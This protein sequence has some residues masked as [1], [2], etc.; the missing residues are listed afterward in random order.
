MDLFASKL[1]DPMDGHY[2]DYPGQKSVIVRIEFVKCNDVKPFGKGLL[3]HRSNY[4]Y[5]NDPG[6]WRTNVPNYREIFYENIYDNID[7]RFYFNENRLKY[8]F[9]VLPGGEPED[10]VISV[11]G[12]ENLYID[13]N[14]DLI[15]KSSFFDIKDSG[16]FVFQEN[17]D[18]EDVIDAEFALL[19]SN[20]Y[21]FKIEGD[22]DPG[23]PL[24]IDPGL[25]YS[26]F[27]GGSA[28]DYGL[29]IAVD[30]YHNA[31]VSGR[32]LSANFPVKN[33]AT[34]GNLSG[35]IDYFVTK[36]N[37]NGTSL[38]YSTFIGG[39]DNEGTTSPG[40]YYGG[41]IA[42]DAEGNA[43]LTGNTPSD[44][45]PTT[46]NAFD[47]TYNE[48]PD[49]N[50][51]KGDAFVTKISAN[52]SAL[53][54][55]TYIGGKNGDAGICIVLDS[56]NRAYV[57]GTTVS[58]NFPVTTGA[59]KTSQTN[60]V[61]FITCLDEKGEKVLYSTFLGGSNKDQGYSICLDWDGNVCV[62]GETV[63][64]DFPTTPGVLNE[65]FRP[66]SSASSLFVSKLDPTLSK[67]LNST[68]FIGEMWASGIVC[69][70]Q[71]NIYVA[72]YTTG[73]NFRTTPNAYDTSFNGGGIN[74]KLDGFIS[75]FNSNLTMLVYSTYYGGNGNDAIY[76][77]MIDSN[78][79]L[80][81]TG[82]TY[83]TNL[84]STNGTFSATINGT[85]DG[86]LVALNTATPYLLY[87]SYIGGGGMEWCYGIDVDSYF[88]IYLT[89]Q[90]DNLL[91][92]T[93]GSFQTNFSGGYYDAF[94]WKMGV[95]LPP[96]V[97]ELGI[98]EHVLYRP[99]SPHKIRV[100]AKVIDFEN[101][102]YNLTPYFECRIPDQHKWFTN[103]LSEPEFTNGYWQ[104]FININTTS[105]TGYYCFR[106]RFNDSDLYSTPWR[107]LQNALLVLNNVP[108]I[109]DFNISANTAYYGDKRHFMAEGTD[110][111][112][113]SSE[114][115]YSVQYKF[116]SEDNWKN[117]WY[118]NAQFK[119]PGKILTFNISSD[120][121]YGYYD[122]RINV[123]DCDFAYSNW[124]YA[125]KS[126]LV[127]PYQPVL[128]L[129]RLSKYKIYRTEGIGITVNCSDKDSEKKTLAV[130]LQYTRSEIENW[131]NLPLQ[132]SGTY[133]ESSLTTN[134][135]TKLGNY[136][137]RAR[138]CDFEKNISPWYYLNN[139][140]LVLNNI[141]TAFDLL[142][143]PKTCLRGT[144][145]TIT[146]D[147]SDVENT[148]AELTPE[149]EYRSPGNTT[150]LQTDLSVPEYL[151]DMW[152][153]V[154]KPAFSAPVGMYDFRVR[155][156][157]TDGN[158]SA[159]I[160]AN[161]S[162]YIWNMYPEVILF[163]QSPGVVN[164]TESIHITATGS[165]LET[166]Q[167]LL[168]CLIAFRGP[169]ESEWHNLEAEYDSATEIWFTDLVTATTFELGYYSFMVIFEDADGNSTDPVFDYNSVMVLNNLPVIS[170]N[171]DDIELFTKPRRINLTAFGYDV[172]TARNDL[173]WEISVMSIDKELF[174]IDLKNISTHQIV[175]YPVL[176]NFAVDDITV[177]L[178]DAD[179]A[180]TIKRDVTIFINS[181][182]NEGEDDNDPG[183]SPGPGKA[184]PEKDN[185][186]DDD[187][188]NR[189]L[190]FYIN[191]H[192]YLIII[193][194]IIFVILFVMLFL[195]RNRRRVNGNKE[196]EAVPEPVKDNSAG[197]AAF[198]QD[199]KQSDIR[200]TRP[201]PENSSAPRLEDII[202]G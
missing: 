194:V 169:S 187:S 32:T 78:D 95:K 200:Y 179:S 100:F 104:A 124:S 38:I 29:D 184:N 156:C 93:N 201:V 67:L 15:I 39:R 139:S 20:C 177:I 11:T 44:D 35:M 46:K 149:L 197:G 27:L 8:D 9:I 145:A 143:K 16:L 122:F 125:N 142:I 58:P 69:D 106:V 87:A 7:L 54:Y 178:T 82:I 49:N 141:P 202:K 110:V 116:S 147:G 14:N 113:A 138:V 123:S 174:D 74:T 176:N 60:S 173:K 130:T 84:P 114:L 79:N 64:W 88:N 42:V 47:K 59:Y 140:L 56:K 31:C 66:T 152:Q 111:E 195:R 13:Q 151:G 21:G 70:S 50:A 10:I 94:V 182:I 153:S 196:P 57:L 36:L 172:E 2:D 96:M 1:I 186:M 51:F 109:T 150:W 63:S 68:Y 191:E 128:D 28:S 19:D 144:P 126:L 199:L 41:I 190:L 92:I 181:R 98:S 71:N 45:F 72:G 75:E 180:V 175:I 162:L 105:Y 4:F 34:K 76:D 48:G 101:T 120:W 188:P 22:Y 81:A 119:D 134:K 164:R 40:N 90:C 18:N 160:Y 52:G 43:Y 167:R 12:T 115:N 171:L 185:D 117:L 161:S 148:G 132:F 23:R 198:D 80:Y 53:L 6:N 77:V 97:L 131:L 112:D 103:I 158:W 107:L 55:S 136:S 3:P 168:V 24:I 37:A 33:N 86:F 166:P 193:A 73:Y 89:G 102:E 157:D 85:Y 170:K 61:A 183:D 137:F 83:S 108:A 133:W 25:I 127:L 99:V 91:T 159:Y 5:G 135:T 155:V 163:N 121:R 129:I 189:I 154:F 65:T 17:G 146:F 165:D 192:Y 30:K 26:T 118:E 62:V